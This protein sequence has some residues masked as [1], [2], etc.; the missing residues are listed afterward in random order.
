MLTVPGVTLNVQVWK[1]E[2]LTVSEVLDVT[3][4]CVLLQRFEAVND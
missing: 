2:S 3:V 4:V 1:L